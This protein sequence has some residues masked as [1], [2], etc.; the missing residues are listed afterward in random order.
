MSTTS[1][2]TSMAPYRIAAETFVIPWNLPAPPMGYFPINSMLIRGAEPTLIDTGAPANRDAWLEAAWSLVAPED[3][4]WV[5]LSHDDRD[6]S[7]NLMQVME[8][9]PN[10]TLLT[11]WFA[12]G[13]MFEEWEIPLDRVRFVNDGDSVD[14][15]D[16]ELVALRPPVFD[17]P[18]TRGV[19]DT[20]T[21]AYWS[22]DTFA[23]NVPEP[24]AES[25]D[26]PDSAFE[27][28]QL[29]GGRLIAPWGELLD[30]AKYQRYV[31]RVQQLDITVVAGCHTP[32]IRGSRVAEAFAT[33]R[34]LP[35]LEAWHDFTQADLESWMDAAAPASPQ[36]PE[37]SPPH[38][39]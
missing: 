3:V 25:A 1:V 15:G 6:H 23:T 30:D 31:D 21:G 18:T 19:F 16:R 2:S 10:A 36:V 7:G 27:D 12:V 11:S 8:A 9:C 4:R 28:G 32:V 38:E 24:L 29:L 20:H 33:T 37:Q 35:N 5:F 17:N 39:I 14:L 13:R 26:L 34:R 22:V